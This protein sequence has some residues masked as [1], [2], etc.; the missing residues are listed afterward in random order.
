MKM[1][2][3]ETV[4]GVMQRAAELIPEG[5]ISEEITIENGVTT[6]TARSSGGVVATLSEETGI[7]LS[8]DTDSNSS[9]EEK[10]QFFAN[11]LIGMRGACRETGGDLGEPRTEEGKI[12]VDGEK[13]PGEPVTITFDL[14]DQTLSIECSTSRGSVNFGSGRATVKL[15]DKSNL[16]S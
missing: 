15:E 1:S 11:M 7:S 10:T 4:T 6:V 3:I 12:I 2:G 13:R 16:D 9:N 14:T 8:M 5:V